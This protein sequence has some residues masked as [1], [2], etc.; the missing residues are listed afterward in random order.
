MILATLAFLSIAAQ[1]RA[2]RDLV[3]EQWE[4]DRT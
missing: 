4:K 3:L 2:V 1:I